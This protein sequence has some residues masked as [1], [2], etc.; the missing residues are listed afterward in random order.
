MQ[1]HRFRKE[2]VRKIFKGSKEDVKYLDNII[3]QN[4]KKP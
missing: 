1:D 2:R 4:I 3:L